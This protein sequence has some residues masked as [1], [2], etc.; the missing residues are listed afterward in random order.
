MML[1]DICDV[2]FCCFRYL[3]VEMLTIRLPVQPPCRKTPVSEHHHTSY[4]S[5][6]LIHICEHFT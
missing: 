1:Y 2:T 3:C 4:F 6:N 5:V